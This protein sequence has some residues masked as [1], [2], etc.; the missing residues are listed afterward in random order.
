MDKQIR[1]GEPAE[2]FNDTQNLLGEVFSEWQTSNTDYNSL[3]Q[4]LAEAYYS[5]YEDEYLAAYLQ[6]P[7]YDDKPD[8]DFLR[9]YFDL[10]QQGYGFALGEDCLYLYLYR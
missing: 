6:Y 3:E 7:M 4:V 5:I 2:E 8:N 1:F 10:W 9:P